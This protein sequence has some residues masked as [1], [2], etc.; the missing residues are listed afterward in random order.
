MENLNKVRSGRPPDLELQRRA[1]EPPRSGQRGL[2]ACVRRCSYFSGDRSCNCSFR[3]F[4][5]AYFDPKHGKTHFRDEKLSPGAEMWPAPGSLS[6][7]W[8]LCRQEPESAPSEALRPPAG[9]PPALTP[10]THELETKMFSTHPPPPPANHCRAPLLSGRGRLHGPGYPDHLIPVE[11]QGSR[12]NQLGCAAQLPGTQAPTGQEHRG[13]GLEERKALRDWAGGR[14]K[15]EGVPES[16][17]HG[18]AGP[19]V[20]GAVTMGT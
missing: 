4:L 15:L 13:S 19:A 14:R 9:Y 8:C 18:G 11:R 16:E 17:R 7:L 2:C 20:P 10:S 1:L 3:Q 12:G 5:K 6:A